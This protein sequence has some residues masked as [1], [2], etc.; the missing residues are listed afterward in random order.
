MYK[1]FGFKSD[2]NLEFSIP[3][4]GEKYAYLLGSFNAFNEGSFR[5]K[6]EDGRWSIT[7]EL[8]EGVWHYAFSLEGKFALD[9]ENPHH[10]TYRRPSYKFERKTSVAMN[11]LSILRQSYP[12]KVRLSI[13]SKS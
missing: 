4:R 5:M 11:F 12:K 3:H 13:T 7:V 6:E 8:P 1:T 9:P 2:E 10:E